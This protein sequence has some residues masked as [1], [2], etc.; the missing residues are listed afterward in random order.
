MIQPDRADIRPEIKPAQG[1]SGILQLLPR[2]IRISTLSS[3]LFL[4]TLA[5]SAGAFSLSE[6]FQALSGNTPTAEAA[7]CKVKIAVL[8]FHFMDNP[9][10]PATRG[11]IDPDDFVFPPVKF[12]DAVIYSA[13]QE[14]ARATMVPSRDHEEALF[15]LDQNANAKGSDQSPALRVEIGF[16][17]DRIRQDD[18]R[19][20]TKGI[21][22]RCGRFGW[23]YG[24]RVA[25]DK[26][27][28]QIAETGRFT[29]RKAGTAVDEATKRV[30]GTAAGIA[31][32]VDDPQ[33]NLKDVRNFLE[34][35]KKES[36]ESKKKE[37]EKVQAQTAK[38]PT[39][40]P[41]TPVA[42]SPTTG[43]AP[44][45][46]RTPGENIQ[47][48][49]V[50]WVGER[51]KN[52]VD[53]ANAVRQGVSENAGGALPWVVGAAGLLAYRRFVPA[54]AYVIRGTHIPR[55]V[56]VRGRRII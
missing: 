41:P 38:T 26:T 51:A 23:F 4:A 11:L 15:E 47:T 56:T 35:A 5:G 53:I 8:G 49:V 17:E 39:I 1:K 30:F 36:Q 19:P 42:S 9:T 29:V 6:V 31:P 54:G 33:Q 45:A 37:M 55:H 21:V 13:G 25:T 34:Q 18:G 16:S 12:G 7:G 28:E 20:V 43:P 40:V 50:G 48:I 14:I 3:R 27:I 22:V 44:E 52:T 32:K 10:A 2:E 24:G 46:G